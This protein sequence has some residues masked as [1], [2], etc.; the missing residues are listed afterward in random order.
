MVFLVTLGALVS[1]E[2]Y[3]N[4]QLVRNKIAD[5]MNKGDSNA[6][7]PES[8]GKCPGGAAPSFNPTVEFQKFDSPTEK[9]PLIGYAQYLKEGDVPQ[10][11]FSEHVDRL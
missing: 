7:R 10:T 9:P 11:D 6:G 4:S 8:N 3:R 2:I 5:Y 1:L